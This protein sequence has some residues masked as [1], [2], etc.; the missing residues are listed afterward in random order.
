[1][2]RRCGKAWGAPRLPVRGMVLRTSGS[3]A[4]GGGRGGGGG[5]RLALRGDGVDGVYATSRPVSTGEGIRKIDAGVATRS[6]ARRTPRSGRAGRV[7]WCGDTRDGERPGFAC[8]QN[9]PGAAVAG[10]TLLVGLVPGAR[11]VLRLRVGCDWA[12]RWLAARIRMCRLPGHFL[13]VAQSRKPS[14]RARLFSTAAG[15]STEDSS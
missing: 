1:M 10:A 13:S 3:C 9:A 12:Q 4:R 2:C 15:Q 5:G 8:A 7:A 14:Q 11:R 6:W